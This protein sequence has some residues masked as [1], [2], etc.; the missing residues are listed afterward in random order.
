MIE[1]IVKNAL[2]KFQQTDY[3]KGGVSIAPEMY[4]AI[5]IKVAQEI[6]NLA[7][8]PVSGQLQAAFDDLMNRLKLQMMYPEMFEKSIKDKYGL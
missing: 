2:I 5:A 3:K 8:V 6:K 7:N 1:K 4:D